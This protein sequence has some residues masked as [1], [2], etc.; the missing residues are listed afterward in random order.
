MGVDIFSF[1]HLPFCFVLFCFLDIQTHSSLL[2]Q[3]STTLLVVC[4]WMALATALS[5]KPLLFLTFPTSTPWLGAM[6]RE[7]SQPIVCSGTLGQLFNVTRQDVLYHFCS[8]F[9]EPWWIL[10]SHWGW[11]PSLSS[12]LWPI[13]SAAALTAAHCRKKFL[14]LR[15]TAIKVYGYRHKYLEGNL[16]ACPFREITIF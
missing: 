2:S 16:T 14:W 1:F 5:R 12:A 15:L 4:I 8:P 3:P 10:M 13:S 6:S 11:A 7:E 9:P